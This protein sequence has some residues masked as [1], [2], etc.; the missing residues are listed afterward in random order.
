MRSISNG[1]VEC[2][3]KNFQG[4]TCTFSCDEKYD[5]I[6]KNISTCTQFDDES[7]NWDNKRPICQSRLNIS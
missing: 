2:S 3:K 1:Q 5:L 6:G 7:V 4:S